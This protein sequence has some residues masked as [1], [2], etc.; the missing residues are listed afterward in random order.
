MTQ[1]P[2]FDSDFAVTGSG[3]RGSVSALRLAEKGYTVLRPHAVHGL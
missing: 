1:Q 2:P 3:Y